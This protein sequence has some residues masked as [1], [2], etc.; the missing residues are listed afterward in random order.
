MVVKLSGGLFEI[1]WRVG[2]VWMIG[3]AEYVF[4]GAFVQRGE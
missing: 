3:L 2:Y 1:E 4:I